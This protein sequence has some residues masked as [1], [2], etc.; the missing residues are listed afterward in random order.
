MTQKIF[1]A[2][3]HGGLNYKSAIQD[4]F[5]N[6]NWVDL[7]PHSSDSVDYPDFAHAL[8]AA[9]KDDPDALGILVCGS[10]I[11]VSIA[12]NRHPHIRAALCTNATMARL[13][14]A[15]NNAN[16][17]CLGERIIGLEAAYDIVDTFLKAEFEGGR[18]ERRI[19]KI[20]DHSAS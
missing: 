6:Y 13:T 4:K 3:D 1:I 12:A 2:S 11:G 19:D 16:V 14:R 20:N 5:K 17:L 8:A 10:G 18:H 9:L 15:H 7:G